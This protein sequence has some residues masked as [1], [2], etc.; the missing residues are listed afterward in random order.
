MDR[1]PVVEILEG[2][3]LSQLGQSRGL[4]SSSPVKRKP[5]SP[6]SPRALNRGRRDP[7][8]HRTVSEGDDHVA[9]E[10]SGSS[11]DSLSPSPRNSTSTDV[12]IPMLSAGLGGSIEL[13]SDDTTPA[14]SPQ[15][16]ASP[17]KR[18]S[19]NPSPKRGK[20]VSPELRR[21]EE[22]ELSPRS[23]NKKLDAA[24]R[25]LVS[26]RGSSRRDLLS[27]AINSQNQRLSTKE[28]HDS[29]RKS[30]R[31]SR[32]PD[33]DGSAGD[34]VSRLIDGNYRMS[35]RFPLSVVFSLLKTDIFL[36]TNLPIHAPISGVTITITTVVTIIIATRFQI[37]Q[38]LVQTAGARHLGEE[39]AA[40]DQLP[41]Q[42]TTLWK[43]WFS[44]LVSLYLTF[45]SKFE[46]NE[47]YR[48]QLWLPQCCQW[49]MTSL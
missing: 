48:G 18:K 12:I 11:S 34:R 17:H 10:N 41:V 7:Q 15:H 45:S 37:P 5:P 8:R 36:G 19:R 44:L 1:P 13:E 35:T 38:T 4:G 22:N 40:V 21:G 26:M 28:G 46:I 33:L 29:N 6:R 14:L 23:S 31:K 16:Q 39:E 25:D 27:G 2:D 30:D 9:L 3:G 32:R 47:P 43:T 24:K 42:F 20:S 49:Q